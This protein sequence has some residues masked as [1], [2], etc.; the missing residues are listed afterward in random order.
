MINALF[1]QKTSDTQQDIDDTW[2]I[3]NKTMF[4]ANMICGCRMSN[5]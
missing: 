5:S 2:D 4:G 3:Y 1:Y